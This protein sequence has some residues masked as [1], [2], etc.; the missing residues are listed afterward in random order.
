MIANAYDF[1]THGFI[2]KLMQNDISERQAEAIV[3]VVY[4]IKQKIISNVI[5]KEDI[6]EMTKVMQKE[7]E[8]VKQ[9]IQ[10]LELR[11]TIRLGTMMACLISMIVTALK[12][13]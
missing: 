5:T 2:K 10:K 1:N 12:L 3:E 8:S 13:L 11:M 9:E 6:Y 7:I 4:D